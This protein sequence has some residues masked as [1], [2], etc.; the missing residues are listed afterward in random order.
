MD[1]SNFTAE[2]CQH[3]NMTVGL[4]G[5]SCPNPTP[6]PFETSPSPL[7]AS[8]P[9]REFSPSGAAVPSAMPQWALRST[10]IGS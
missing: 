6:R 8:A 2:L 7:C 10:S 4:P 9:L 5:F 1:R 3:R